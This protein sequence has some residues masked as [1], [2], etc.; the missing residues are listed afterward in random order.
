[1]ISVNCDAFQETKRKTAQQEFLAHLGCYA[2]PLSV[3]RKTE[4][5]RYAEA[6]QQRRTIK[7]ETEDNN[8]ALLRIHSESHACT[9]REKHQA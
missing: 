7:T 2:S 8:V 4:V 9:L 6:L 1:M 5:A 3:R